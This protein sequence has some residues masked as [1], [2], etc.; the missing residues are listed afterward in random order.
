MNQT[1]KANHSKGERR[2]NFVINTRDDKN[3][4]AVDSNDE[5]I[6]IANKR[7][8]FKKSAQTDNNNGQKTTPHILKSKFDADF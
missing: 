6:H 3:N 5:N 2:D 8:T 7:I 4:E 1:C